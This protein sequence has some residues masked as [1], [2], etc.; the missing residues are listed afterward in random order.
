MENKLDWIFPSYDYYPHC[1]STLFTLLNTATFSI[2]LSENFPAFSESIF[3]LKYG[4][5]LL[6]FIAIFCHW[7]LLPLLPHEFHLLCSKKRTLKFNWLIDWKTISALCT[8]MRSILVSS[9][10]IFQI[11]LHFSCQQFYS[12]IKWLFGHSNSEFYFNLRHRSSCIIFKS[13][14][15]NFS[16]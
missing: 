7:Y 13:R 15:L 11:Y 14:Y 2:D 8:A 6:F 1:Q 10:V 3:H 9:L 4:L 16:T 5:K 12:I